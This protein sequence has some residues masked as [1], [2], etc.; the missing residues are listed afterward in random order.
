MSNKNWDRYGASWA[1]SEAERNALIAELA[2]PDVRYTDPSVTLEGAEA[3]SAY[4]GEF[5]RQFP[6]KRFEITD[7]REHNQQ[8]L[9]NWRLVDGAGKIAMLGTSHARLAADGKF[10]SF[11]G[12][13]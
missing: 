3:L 4:M 7:V 5:Q 12:F 2:T 10:M 6:G 11:T 13:F 8:S 1:Q 9:A